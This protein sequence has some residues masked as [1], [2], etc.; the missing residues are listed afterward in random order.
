MWTI[1]DARAL[2]W[3]AVLGL[4]LVAGGVVRQRSAASP[5]MADQTVLD[6]RLDAA[7]RIDLNTADV[8]ALEALPGVGPV[9]A[10]AIIQYRRAHGPLAS[11]DDVA[12]IPG[13]R[14]SVVEQV[15]EFVQV[16]AAGGG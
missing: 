9:T 8:V 6:A 16:S 1:G 5:V 2:R 15:R 14:P 10:E 7:R 11:V 13:V 3:L 12:A 4:F